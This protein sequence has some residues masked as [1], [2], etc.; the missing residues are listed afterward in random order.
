MDGVSGTDMFDLFDLDN[1][2]DIDFETAYK[3]ISNFDEEISSINDG[4]TLPKLNFGELA[5]DD[6]PAQTTPIVHQKERPSQQSEHEGTAEVSIPRIQSMHNAP[7]QVPYSV[8][9]AQKVHHNHVSTRP[10]LLSTY[11]SNAIEHFLDSL[12]SQNNSAA[13][14]NQEE[15][16]NM[17]ELEIPDSSRGK[18]FIDQ[19]SKNGKESVC[20]TPFSYSLDAYNPPIVEIPDISISDSEI[21][22]TILS[23]PSQLK[24]W[25]HVE[26]ERLRRNNTKRTFDELISMTRYPRGQNGKVSKPATEKRIPKHTLLNFIVEDMKSILQANEQLEILLNE[27][28]ES[29]SKKNNDKN[30]VI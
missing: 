23:N 7:S 2:N 20:P 15:T 12:I 25:K 6:T 17:A 5:D 4:I 28:K 10:E 26:V 18:E 29:R 30:I 13:P 21:P 1:G 9:N 8:L 19:S 24:K 16:I 27:G 22:P 11:E 3:M 14:K